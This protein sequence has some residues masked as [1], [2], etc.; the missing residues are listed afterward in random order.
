M[1]NETDNFVYEN[2]NSLS[3][4]ICIDM[5]NY[6]ENKASN[7]YQ[8]V[9]GRGV[10]ITVKDTVDCHITENNEDTFKYYRLLSKELVYNIKNYLT[11]LN[12]KY[13]PCNDDVNCKDGDV[14]NKE[15]YKYFD[16]ENL[17]FDIFQMQRYKKNIGKFTIHHDFNID[18]Y[19]G[20]RMFVYMWYLNDVVKGG[21]TNLKNTIDIKPKMGKLLIFPA[22]WNYPHCGNIPLSSDKY[23]I[24]GWVKV[25]IKVS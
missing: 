1:L 2:N 8:G 10:D 17:Y 24:T 5:I 15:S 23:I 16:G 9:C 4:E 18:K 20:C 21:E 25:K 22:S 19:N 11:L 13:L 14:L 12:N 3:N 7:K 6:F